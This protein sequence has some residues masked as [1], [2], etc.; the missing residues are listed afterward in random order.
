MTNSFQDRLALYRYNPIGLGCWA[1]GGRNWGGQSEK[2]AFEVMEAA[3][4]NGLRHFD[5][6]RAYGVSE[7]LLG[8]FLKESGAD[9]F[10]ASKVYPSGSRTQVKESL[11]RSLEALGRDCIDLYYLHWPVRNG[12]NAEPMEALLEAKEDGLIGAIGVSNYSR[13]NLEEILKIG[14]VD[15]FQA[16]YHLFWRVVERDVLPLCKKHG[17]R[18][19]TYSSLG[20][21]I[22]S[23][24]F[25]RQPEFPKGDHRADHVIHFREDVWPEVYNAVEQLKKVANAVGRPLS[26]LALQWLDARKGVDSILVGARNREQLLTNVSALADPVGSEVLCEL[27]EI[28]DELMC[29]LP[30]APTLF[31]SQA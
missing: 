21:G 9:V 2:A 10:L 30:A 31:G 12:R 19:V 14:P 24:K 28:S 23:G 1:L 6:A 8:R 26:H 25:P 15:F 13:E 11:Q 27:S 7:K 16:G 18:L 17:I 22:L 4:E 29:K 5:T 3:F 20:Q